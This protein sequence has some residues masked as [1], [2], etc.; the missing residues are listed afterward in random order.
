MDGIEALVSGLTPRKEFWK[1]LKYSLQ[2]TRFRIAN[3]RVF[4]WKVELIPT[5]SGDGR[6]P[7]PELDMRDKF[8]ATMVQRKIDGGVP[9]DAAFAD[10]RDEIKKQAKAEGRTCKICLTTIKNA[11]YTA[12]PKSSKAGKIARPAPTKKPQPPKAR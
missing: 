4:P 10:M 2:P 7:D 11:Y 6:R 3:N 12:F 9:P 5:C 8:L 1:V